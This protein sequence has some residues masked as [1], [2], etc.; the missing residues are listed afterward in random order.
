[1]ST[2][3]GENSAT[4]VVTGGARGIGAA[5]ADLLRAAGRR[6]VVWDRSAPAEPLNG[7]HYSRVNVRSRRAV[8]AAAHTID[9]VDLLINAAGI[10]GFGRAEDI[11]AELWSDVVET[12]L[13][14]PFHTAQALFPALRNAKGQVVNVAS[15]TAY[16]P[17]AGRV[18]YCTSKSG[19]LMLTRVL[20]LEW[21]AYGIR[22]I[23]V[24]P[25]YTETPMVLDAISSGNLDQ[26][27]ILGRTPQG[28]MATAEEMA[29][30][31]VGLTEE[32][33]GHITGQDIVVDGGWSVNGAY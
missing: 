29:E 11:S 25:G 15:I 33:F 28:R 19:V 26:R 12:N 22:V 9:R 24:S 4:A 8:Q 20:A 32:R 17:G 27:T 23:S 10:T 16:A 2:L 1:M 5:C 18:A 3:N 31:V 6:V 21:A 7:V 14:G 30:A 13:H